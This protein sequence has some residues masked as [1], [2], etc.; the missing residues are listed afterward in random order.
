MDYFV[1][2]VVGERETWVVDT[3]FGTLDATARQR[4]L[5]RSAAE[6]LA[7]VGVDAGAITDVVLTHLHYDHAGGLEQFPNA[8][9]HVQEREMAFATGRHMT[10]ADQSHGFTADHVARTRPPCA[11]G[12]RRLP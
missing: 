2:A 12:P 3:G 6:A 11:R 5:L 4:R 10:S 1:W 7:T 8:R 9:F